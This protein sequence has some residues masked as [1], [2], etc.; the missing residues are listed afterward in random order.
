ME[1]LR[2]KSIDFIRR[3]STD[4]QRR[5][6]TDSQGKKAGGRSVGFMVEGQCLY[7]GDD[8]EP[9]A[10]W[11]PGERNHY[12]MSMYS[13]PNSILTSLSLPD[14]D[15]FSSLSMY[16]GQRSPN[17]PFRSVSMD[18]FCYSAHRETPSSSPPAVPTPNPPLSGRFA[19]ICILL[20]C[21]SKNHPLPNPHPRLPHPHPPT[22]LFSGG[23]K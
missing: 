23:Y 7:P 20:F 1:N 9:E 12:G 18:V 3:K 11:Y 8:T 10:P 21:P 13:D 16:G 22:P 4:S 15:D 14:P 17:T 5:R 19:S 6:S 2:R